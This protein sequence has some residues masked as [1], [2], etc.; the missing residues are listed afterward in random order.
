M[1]MFQVQLSVAIYYYLFGQ[2][3]WM[4]LLLPVWWFAGTDTLV[5]VTALV[6]RE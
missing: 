2:D 1:F 5:V 6:S 4:V 3:S